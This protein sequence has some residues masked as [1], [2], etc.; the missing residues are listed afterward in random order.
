MRVNEAG[1]AL[2]RTY[3]GFRG[4]AYR[5]P[6]G[7]WTIG[8]GHT[9]MAGP[10]DVKPKMRMTKK[11]AEEV[12]AS[13]VAVFA[14]DIARY[15]KAD[16]N[17]NQFA[18][19]VSFA[20]NVGVGAFRS[21]SVLASVNREDFDSI[22]R[23]LNMWVKAGGRV[24]PGLVKRRASEGML[25]MKDPRG[26][27]LF[28][29]QMPTLSEGEWREVEEA[30]GLLDIPM[31]TP[32]MKSTTNWAAFG[33]FFATMGAL[34]S[35][36]AARFREASWEASDFTWFLP[37]ASALNITLGFAAVATL[38]WIIKERRTKALEDDV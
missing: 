38:V 28:A 10:P 13:D 26:M 21:S 15:I 2:I 31:G 24:L 35:G 12:M 29:G 20:Y 8:Y 30:R 1:L 16:L 6:A 32:M 19:L 11:Q 7:V 17:D 9:S 22:P 4:E 27:N 34:V 25:F 3:E 18:A 36:A 33:Q 37:E 5:C 14:S 23:R